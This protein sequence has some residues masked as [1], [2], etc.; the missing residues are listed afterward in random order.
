MQSLYTT[1]NQR[2]SVEGL[3]RKKKIRTK[4]TVFVSN[5]IQVINI[6]GKSHCRK[7]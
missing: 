7:S 2:N 4:K 5:F 3:G 6:Q 1:N